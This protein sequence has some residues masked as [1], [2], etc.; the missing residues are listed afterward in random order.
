MK[1]FDDVVDEIDT[2]IG[3]GM[4]VDSINDVMSQI[5]EKFNLDTE[6]YGCTPTGL[7]EACFELKLTQ[8][9]INE[10]CEATLN[11]LQDSV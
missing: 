5:G 7:E 6:Q 4:D 3:S 1:T 11:S 2:L 10:I 8:E 9:Q